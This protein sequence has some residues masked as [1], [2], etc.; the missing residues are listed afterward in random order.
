MHYSGSSSYKKNLTKESKTLSKQNNAW[1]KNEVS[2]NGYTGKY[3]VLRIKE[4][5]LVEPTKL[6][7]PDLVSTLKYCDEINLLKTFYP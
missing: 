3:I 4:C 5:F 1:K 2:V 6:S 7:L